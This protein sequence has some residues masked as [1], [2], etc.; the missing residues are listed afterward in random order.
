MNNWETWEPEKGEL[1]PTKTVGPSDNK[2]PWDTWEPKR[3]HAE[4]ARR[5]YAEN[6]AG[7]AR[8][9]TI[10]ERN[11]I[12]FETALNR[13]DEAEI[14]DLTRRAKSAGG[15]TS[16]FLAR[17]ENLTM[18]KDDIESLSYLEKT[19]QNFGGT[20]N[21]AFKRQAI[22]AGIGSVDAAQNRIFGSRPALPQTIGNLD[23][24]YISFGG[25]ATTQDAAKPKET[26]MNQAFNELIEAYTKSTEKTA[27]LTPEGLTTVQKGIR[28]GA[29]SLTVQGP[30]LALTIATR[31]PTFMT[32]GIVAQTA[33]N[34]Y[35]EARSEGLEPAAAARFASIQAGI[36]YITEKIPAGELVKAMGPGWKEALAKFAISDIAG[37]QAATLLGTLNEVAHGLD[38]EMAGAGSIGEVAKIQAERQAVALVATIFA[39]GAQSSIA[40]SAGKIASAL[41]E[42]SKSDQKSLDDVAKTSSKIKMNDLAKETYRQFINK[43]AEDGGAETVSI[44]PEAARTF[45]QNPDVPRETLE[46]EAAKKI[47]EKLPDALESG[48]DIQIDMGT[49][50]ADIANTEIDSA[51]RGHMHINSVS[52]S[53][54]ANFEI[55]SEIK[56]AEKEAKD[57]GNS[58]SYVFDNVSQQLQDAGVTQSSSETYAAMHEAFFAAQARRL[59]VD[60]KTLFDSLGLNVTQ[61]TKQEILGEEILAQ[62]F[63]DIKIS[64]EVSIGGKKA[65]LTQSAQKMYDRAAKRKNVVQGIARCLGG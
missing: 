8:A 47:L 9:Q 3:P 50:A 55:E 19:F 22:G 63:G 46:S 65:K 5:A 21:E 20:V 18:A 60:A 54:L 35:G 30:A 45:F 53:M 13:I 11:G 42:R 58:E 37:E 48:N 15:K 29:E 64:Q 56:L 14:L 25:D 24:E 61:E 4:A 17:P 57:F 49:F 23:P 26:E 7:R 32:G 39:G 31:N 34:S 43:I 6:P 51:L 16:E 38:E 33:A 40:T 12:S 1:L 36:E 27:G 44:D 52:P 59:G 10:A 2:N 41:E 28:S 62:N